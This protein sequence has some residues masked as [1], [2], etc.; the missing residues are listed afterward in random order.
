MLL[1][2]AIFVL[3]TCLLSYVTSQVDPAANAENVLTTLMG[4]GPMIDTGK[5]L[6][7]GMEYQQ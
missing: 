5:L 4:G 2:G 7:K 1:S 6:C 3:V